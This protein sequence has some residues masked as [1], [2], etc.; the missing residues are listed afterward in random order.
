MKYLYVHNTRPGT[1][2]VIYPVDGPLTV[3]PQIDGKALLCIGGKAI[4]DVDPELA[5]ILVREIAL[6]FLQ[7]DVHSITLCRDFSEKRQLQKEL[8]G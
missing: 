8:G 2:D 5:D 7:R 6:S 3:T 1:Q 4:F